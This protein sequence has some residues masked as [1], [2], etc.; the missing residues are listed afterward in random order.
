[1]PEAYESINEAMER[2]GRS[3]KRELDARVARIESEG[4]SASMAVQF[5][6]QDPEQDE[7][8]L[9]RVPIWIAYASGQGAPVS[10][11]TIDAKT[12]AV[13]PKVS[14]E[15]MKDLGLAAARKLFGTEGCMQKW[16]YLDYQGSI[17]AIT[18]KLRFMQDWELVCVVPVPV[19]IGIFVAIF[20]RPIPVPAD[21]CT[22]V[23]NMVD[24]PEPTPTPEEAALAKK[25][26]LENVGADGCVA[27]ED[28]EAALDEAR[29]R[30]TPDPA[31]HFQS[32][33]IDTNP[34]G[35]VQPVGELTKY[36]DD[37]E[38]IYLTA[39]YPGRICDCMGRHK[40]DC[41]KAECLG[42]C[43]CALR[44]HV[45]H[46]SHVNNSTLDI[47]RGSADPA[48]PFNVTVSTKNMQ[49]ER[50]AIAEFINRPLNNVEDV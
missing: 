31:P 1:M 33:Y 13:T 29:R 35:Y 11:V 37:G 38:T 3:Q 15:E 36:P 12:G 44:G 4:V 26:A 28:V 47:M 23:C 2:R 20:K 40:L 19:N 49:A 8:G 17:D 24:P 43:D 50:D 46:R 48:A 7:A 14:P 16:E 42:C 30:L 41:A 21:I 25:I 34:P 10:E 27:S 32:G 39:T 6:P 45:A 22:G 5:C 9:W 18:N